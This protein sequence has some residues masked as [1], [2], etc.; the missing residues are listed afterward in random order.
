MYPDVSFSATSLGCLDDEDASTDPDN[1]SCLSDDHMHI[2]L[3]PRP[4]L[5]LAFPPSSL[6]KSLP[7]GLA[8]GVVS[9]ADGPVTR[10]QSA[11]SHP[12]WHY[13]VT[14]GPPS[15]PPPSL[16]R[17]VSNPPSRPLGRCASQS[18]DIARPQSRSSHRSSNDSDSA[19]SPLQTR[20]RADNDVDGEADHVARL[21]EQYIA[22]RN[23]RSSLSGK[24]NSFRS[25]RAHLHQLRRGK[26]EAGQRF[27]A[28]ARALLPDSPQLHQLLQLFNA[29]QST[30]LGCLEAEQRIGHTVDALQ[31]D[32]EGLVPQEAA[33][34]KTAMDA[35]EITHLGTD[36]VQ[37][38]PTVKSED[39]FLRGISGD[40]PENYHPLYQKLRAAFSELQLAKEL[41]AN[42]QM[43]R[44]ALH[45]Q[46]TQPLTEDGL[47]L[48]ETYGDAGRKKAL[49]L[50]A[51][52]L[53][54]EDD[55]EQLRE[56]DILEQDAYDDIKIFT[57]QVKTLQQECR[58]TGVLP[59]TSCF[60]QG[61]VELDSFYREEI[62]LPPS[63]FDSNDE[64]ATL[65]HPVFP[66]LLSNPTHLLHG[67]PQTSL[68]SLKRAIQLPPDAPV[69]DRQVKQ[70]AREANMH[71]L[72][73][74]TESN[75]KNEYIN[76]WLLHKLHNSAMEAELLWT[77]FRSRLKILD[78]DRWQQDVLY[79]W[80]RDQSAKPVSGD[81]GDS[82]TDRISKFVGSR[83]EF[84]TLP[85]SDS[86][87]LDG[88]RSWNLDSSW[89]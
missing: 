36:K 23:Q 40:R 34:Y 2:G 78:I 49:E 57:D 74:S 68:Q 60:H 73:S 54:T 53:M 5:P 80:W 61:S 11:H 39:V 79:F 66:L 67:F 43:K 15:R 82:S 52:P 17:P 37:H 41:L 8:V 86:G 85:Y 12:R 21:T 75:D 4:L 50:R 19:Y 33:F 47:D 32:Q 62:R 65:A 29:M 26:D 27:M 63:P 31:D 69:R 28:A 9:Q 13:R 72:L 77:T 20:D 71:S 16:T 44:A 59:S 87:Q 88:L 81:V 38:D 76:R 56:Y 42:T 70:A 64:S 1:Y 46:K 83:K 6:S 55:R 30:Q 58:E 48:L 89:L 84:S 7:S 25:Q 18:S 45:A 35:L 51:I 22:I 24:L 10:S 3:S 14:S